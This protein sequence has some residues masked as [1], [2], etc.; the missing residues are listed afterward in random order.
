MKFLGD[1][2]TYVDEAFRFS[3]KYDSLGGHVWRLV[4]IGV[5][6]RNVWKTMKQLRVRVG[7]HAKFQI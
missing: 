7:R 6:R 2:V 4:G 1:Q 3:E 5:E